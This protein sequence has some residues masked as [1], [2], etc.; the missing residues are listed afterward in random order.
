MDL[1]SRDRPNV[2][3]PPPLIFFAFLCIAVAL[4]HWFGFDYPR[5]SLRLRN[6]AAL[7]VFII[8]GYL[9]LH[10]FVVL[11]RR[12]TNID[13]NKPTIK[14]VEDGPFR[15]SR[16][17]MYLSLVLVL[18]ALSILFLSI[19]YL[20]S[21]VSLWLVLDRLAAVP[22]ESYLERKFG[23]RYVDYKSRVRRWI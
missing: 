6:V 17:P 22:E 3:I 8:S 21:A 5:G 7:P 16:N 1:T 4:E 18:L 2:R 14:I 12:G 10:A 13:P 20:L 23:E 11:K 19:W 9:A 15:F